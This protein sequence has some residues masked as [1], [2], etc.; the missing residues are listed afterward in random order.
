MEIL[1][2]YDGSDDA[3]AAIDDLVSAGLPDQTTAVVVT[4]SDVL[5]GLLQDDSA[6]S[7]SFAAVLAKARADARQ[8]MTEAETLAAEGAARVSQLFPAWQVS[9]DAIADSPYWGFVNRASQSKTD[10]IVLG[11]RGH[12]AIESAVLGSVSQNVLQYASCSVRI[13]RASGAVKGGPVKVVVAFDGSSN[14]EATVTSVASRSWPEGSEVRI[15]TATH[16]QTLAKL[17]IESDAQDTVPLMVENVAAQLRNAGLTV[18][19]STPAN[20]PKN[21]VIGEARTWGAHCIFTGARGL[22]RM[23]AVLLGSVSNAIAARAHCSVEVIR[24]TRKA[25]A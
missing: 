8:A 20:D 19:I 5:P 10:L 11:T 18:S 6:S 14:A 23:Q 9:S 21:A 12:S 13:G 16:G 17:L 24:E 25:S 4:A 15:V 22:T 7:E 2:A 1:I 3:K